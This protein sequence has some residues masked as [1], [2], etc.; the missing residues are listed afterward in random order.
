MSKDT[1][2]T[3]PRS[4]PERVHLPQIATERGRF[5]R[6]VIGPVGITRYKAYEW[7][8][9]AVTEG[10]KPQRPFWTW[11]TPAEKGF[12]FISRNP[13][14]ECYLQAEAKV[15]DLAANP[16]LFSRWLAVRPNL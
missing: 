4:K 1:K 3:L 2:I 14:E 7:H 12:C 16:E 15:K 13:H 6:V 11:Q 10:F 5:I 8:R 9:I